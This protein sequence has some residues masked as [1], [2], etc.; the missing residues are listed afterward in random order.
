MLF[1]FPLLVLLVRFPVPVP[2]TRVEDCPFPV[3]G[4]FW[5]GGGKFKAFRMARNVRFVVGNEEK[6][7]S[8]G[9]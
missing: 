3:F 8:A 7:P 9:F 6:S 2:A 1:W 5:E 4:R